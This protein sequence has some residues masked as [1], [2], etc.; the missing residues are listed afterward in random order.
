MDVESINHS[1]NAPAGSWFFISSLEQVV[2]FPVRDLSHVGKVDSLA[3]LLEQT[4][5]CGKIVDAYKQHQQEE[6]GSRHSGIYEFVMDLCNKDEGGLVAQ[7]LQCLL[8]SKHQQLESLS[9]S[10]AS[11]VKGGVTQAKMD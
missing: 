2:S 11:A 6:G 3:I 1:S 9:L 10:L 4:N 5:S 8:E 7:T